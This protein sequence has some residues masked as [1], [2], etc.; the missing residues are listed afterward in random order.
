MDISN[1]HVL[2]Y[3]FLETLVITYRMHITLTA[4]FSTIFRTFSYTNTRQGK[5][6]IQP[7]MSDVQH[8]DDNNINYCIPVIL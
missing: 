4:V 6:C 8:S 1:K 2:L 5:I 3:I 7:N